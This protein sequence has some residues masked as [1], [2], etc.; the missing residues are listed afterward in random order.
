MIGTQTFSG[1]LETTG[2]IFRKDFSAFL[3]LGL[4]SQTPLLVYDI[5]LLST[6]SQAG[7]KGPGT[8][9]VF[10]SLPA[11][12]VGLLYKGAV[13]VQA[14]G[15]YDGRRLSPWQ[16]YGMVLGRFGSLLASNAI[17]IVGASLLMI[18]IVVPGVW[19]YFTYVLVTPIV[20]LE[21]LGAVGALKKA[22]TLARGAFFRILGTVVVTGIL[23]GLLEGVLYL[24]AR[25]FAPGAL[26]H[27]VG[28]TSGVPGDLVAFVATVV[29]G[30]L[31]P[32]ALTV[33]YHDRTMMVEAGTAGA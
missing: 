23:A 18:V 3:V 16:V 32:I 30:S 1:I 14:E 2:L 4:V 31:V 17:L 33:L 25:F 7:L 27:G 8:G 15:F 5:L 13:I 29:A 9:F 20:M 19:F 28:F 26:S 21:D 6:M 11:F 12:L 22:G 24:A 10:L